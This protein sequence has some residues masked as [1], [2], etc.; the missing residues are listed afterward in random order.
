MLHHSKVHSNSQE[1][2]LLQAPSRLQRL[3]PEVG[4][5]CRPRDAPGGRSEGDAGPAPNVRGPRMAAPARG[6]ALGPNGG[7]GKGSGPGTAAE[8]I[9]CPPEQ[10]HREHGGLRGAGNRGGRQGLRVGKLFISYP[11]SEAVC[12]LCTALDVVSGPLESASHMEKFVTAQSSCTII[13][14]LPTALQLRPSPRKQNE[15]NFEKL[16]CNFVPIG[17]LSFQYTT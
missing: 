16:L 13:F 14:C 1:I 17:L 2:V 4:G 10:A 11:A 8:A 15:Y 7:S 9:F 6:S 12:R 5:R 3:R